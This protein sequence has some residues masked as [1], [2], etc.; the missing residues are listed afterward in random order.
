MKE[1]LK[2][3]SAYDKIQDEDFKNAVITFPNLFQSLTPRKLSTTF[4]DLN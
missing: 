1:S 4:K 3:V 2:F